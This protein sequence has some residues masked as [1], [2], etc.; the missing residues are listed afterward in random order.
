MEEDAVDILT[1]HSR[2]FPRMAKA[3]SNATTVG[4]V[5]SHSGHGEKRDRLNRCG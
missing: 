4:E 1:C 2:V 5:D 3:T